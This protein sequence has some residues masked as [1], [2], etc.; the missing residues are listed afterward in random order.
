MVPSRNNEAIAAFEQVNNHYGDDPAPDI[1]EQ[2]PYA[3]HNKGIALRELGRPEEAI[4]AFEQ[5]NNHYGDDP[6]PVM[7]GAELHRR[8]PWQSPGSRRAVDPRGASTELPP[9]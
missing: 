2:A 5:V 7:R 1:R 6:T 9:T 8:C 3:L 4:A